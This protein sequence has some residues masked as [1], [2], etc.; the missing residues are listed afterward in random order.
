METDARYTKFSPLSPCLIG[1]AFD[2]RNALRCHLLLAVFMSFALCCLEKKINPAV[3]L[4]YKS[5]TLKQ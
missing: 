1:V 5:I 3:V 4:Y 2:Q